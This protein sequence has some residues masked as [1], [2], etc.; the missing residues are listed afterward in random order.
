M[1][2][3]II[4]SLLTM[5]AVGTIATAGTVAYFYDTESSTGNTF[6]AG[7]LDLELTSSEHIPFAFSDVVPGWTKTFT[8]TVKNA[9]S[10]NGKLSLAAA[11]VANTEGL[12]P[13]SET[14]DIDE[15][16]ELGANM[17]V[18][19][20]YGGSTVATG[21]L[22][23]FNGTNILTNYPL[24]AGESKMVEIIVTVPTGVENDIQGDVVTGG[25]T[26]RLDQ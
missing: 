6:T 8:Y 14:G 4:A 20:K 9:G 10:I 1:N 2:T 19:V 15:P 11:N 3:K 17:N 7:T 13:E 23:N 22:N 18:Q 24:N 12:N 16:G 5:L 25:F 26:V 21:T